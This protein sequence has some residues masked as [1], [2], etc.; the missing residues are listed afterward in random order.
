MCDVKVAK[1]PQR[2]YN[3]QSSC[4]YTPFTST[5]IQKPYTYTNSCQ[6]FI[7]IVTQC[8]KS[9][10]FTTCLV[11]DKFQTPTTGKLGQYRGIPNT[12]YE[13]LRTYHGG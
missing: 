12:N 13:N 6:H 3:L 8:N 7:Y 4:I 11:P 10:F 5:F 1:P 2:R 9:L